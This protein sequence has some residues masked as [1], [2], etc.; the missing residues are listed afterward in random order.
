MK[1]LFFTD[2]RQLEWQETETPTLIESSDAIVIPRAVAACD[3]DRRIVKGK[4][5]MPGPFILGHEFTG[6]V[7][8]VGSEVT[9]LKVGDRVMASFQPSCG[10]CYSCSI[11]RSSVC[12]SVPTTSMYGIGV[13]GGNWGG[14]I[15]EKI[16]VPW[17]DVNLRV[18]PDH[19]DF[20]TLA[21]ASD[22]LVDGLRAVDDPLN[23]RPGASVL[24]AGDGSVA[25]Y[26]VLC[27]QFLGS[28]QVTFASADE[29]ALQVAE[30]LGAD[31]LPVKDWPRK[32]STH[33]ITMDCTGSAEGLNSVVR[34]TKPAGI[35]TSGSI[36]FGAD[37]PMPLGDMYMKSISFHTG[38]VDSVSNLDRV[39]ELVGAGLDLNKIQ[40]AQLPMEDAI[41]SFDS[42]P[43]SRKLIFTQ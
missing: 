40:P 4:A 7:A 29:V 30:T 3:L 15:A 33:E 22:N 16:R 38:R 24:V 1:A 11:H 18:I 34:S 17:A 8:E 26:T 36:Y 21:P 19:V 31:C 23:Q 12:Q 37:I 2:T 25:L 9:N 20:A 13:A 10:N 39:L 32:F 41:D 42:N 43:F 28:E 5:P 35:C 27:A 14:A 6:E